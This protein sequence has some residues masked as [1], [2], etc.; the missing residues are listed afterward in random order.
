M[1]PRPL[2]AIVLAL[3]LG[4]LVLPPP[5]SADVQVTAKGD[6]RYLVSWTEHGPF[7]VLV[8]D[9]PDA[10]ASAMRL[11]AS[12]LR[13]SPFETPSLGTKRPYF[14]LRAADGTVYRTAQRLIPLQ[15]GSNFRDLGGYPAAGGKHVRWGMLYRSA[16]MPKL[17][18]DDYRYLTSLDIRTA[19]DLR[20]KDERELSPTDWRAK[21]SPRMIEVDYPG[22]V[23]FRRLEGYNGPAREFVTE[24]LYWDIPLLL[25]V[26][27]RD[28]FNEMLQRH[29][30]LVFFD[31]VGE[32]RTGI[33]AA[34]ILSALGVP[35][36]TIDQD[37]LLSTRDRR[38]QNEMADVNLQLY[39]ATNAEARFLIEYRNYAEKNRGAA[40]SAQAS[41]AKTGAAPA[42]A[43]L[44]DSR[45]RPLLEDALEEIEI[46]FGSVTNYLDQ[47]LGVHAADIA[48]LR[49]IYLE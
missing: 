39:A 3:P 35:R 40:Q 23:L 24:R 49:A 22:D 48:K 10:N 21:P 33:A 25:R 17:T 26:E 14:L 16:A 28:L 2:R 11:L 18:D 41:G 9:R 27:Y 36:E 43:P 12:Q 4:F 7:D 42:S 46:E 13:D 37:Y 29:A 44:M 8:S 30:P 31:S 6:S 20:S 47:M 32:D 15:G 34:L 5:A 38:P 45:G 1:T 19:I